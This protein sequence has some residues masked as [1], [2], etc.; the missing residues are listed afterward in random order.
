MKVTKPNF[1]DIQA[2]ILKGHGRDNVLCLFINFEGEPFEIRHWVNTNIA[3]YITSTQEQIDDAATYRALRASQQNHKL[4]DK[5]KEQ[6]DKLQ[7]KLVIGFYFSR[8]GYEKFG[9][10][11][12]RYEPDPAFQ[13]GM[14]HSETRRILN[15]QRSD[16]WHINYRQD[17]DA[18]ILL[19]FDEDRPELLS[20]QQKAFVNFLQ[21]LKDL[22]DPTA[23][24]LFE[25]RGINLRS[26]DGFAIEHFGFAD[27]VSNPVFLNERGQLIDDSWNNV[28]RQK[29]KSHGSYMVFRKLEQR[30]KDFHEKV[31]E[32]HGLGIPKSYAEAQIIGRFRNGSP[33]T[34]SDQPI[35]R[36]GKGQIG[37]DEQFDYL[38][39]ADGHKCPFHA[40]VRKSNP[41]DQKHS[42]GKDRTIARRGLPYDDRPEGS[43]HDANEGLGLLF[44]CFQDNI[45]DKFEFIQADL[46][47]NLQPPPDESGLDP[48]GGQILRGVPAQKWRPHYGK[49]KS[50]D[51][52]F[53]NVVWLKGG[54]Y[55]YAP[56]ISELK[57]P[58]ISR[59][60]PY[61]SGKYKRSLSYGGQSY[62]KK[63]RAGYYHWLRK[64]KSY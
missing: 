15:D 23:R 14:K 49:G 12:E 27:G 57:D 17:I 18:M 48:I 53:R 38:N 62:S 61:R 4:E 26:D 3:P 50:A 7:A 60:V 32:L 58:T 47:N 56:A 34:L 43:T 13:R 31:K 44:I 46:M 1:S 42:R 11:D 54:E 40:H 19:A 24:F 41:R 51:F 45:A 37:W 33:L 55:F 2:N 35:P 39:D 5:A 64:R 9:N 8:F 6:L 20:K 59:N 52:L 22:K 21:R 36:K 29:G 30:V 28:L 63:L 25:E 16:Y 10:N